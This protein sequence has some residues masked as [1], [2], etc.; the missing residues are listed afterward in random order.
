MIDLY[1]GQSGNSLR[2]LIALEECGLP[3]RT[4]KL[5]LQKGEHKQPDFLRIN[6]FGV[7][8][9]MVDPDGPEGSPVTITQS[10]AIM[11][12]AAEKAGR[13][14]PQD[15]ARRAE[16]LQWFML[17]VTDAQ[18]ASAIMLYMDK[19]VGDLT[20]ASRAYLEQ[21]FLT[22][23]RG[24]DAHLAEGRGPYLLGDEAS[25]A[26]LA[27]Y[28]VAKVRR[29]LME[30]GGGCERVLAWADRV[31]ARPAVSRALAA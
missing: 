25:L 15:P 6:P 24:V 3:Y 26:D 17:A 30:Q 21:R 4:R 7:V 12:Y 10:G 9:A 23:M 14:L 8:P 19:N 13:F 22:I 2:A 28:P 5:D 20:D 1:F 27:L 18:P 31:A 16:V 29:P 11:L